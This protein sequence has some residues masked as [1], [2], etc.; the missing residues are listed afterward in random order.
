MSL[1]FIF[2]LIFN[3]LLTRFILRQIIWSKIS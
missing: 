1:E 3:Y 2:V